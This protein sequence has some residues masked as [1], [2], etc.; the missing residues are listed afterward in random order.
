MVVMKKLGKANAGKIAD[1]NFY[2]GGDGV[3]GNGSAVGS[4]QFVVYNGT[5]E[6]VTVTGLEPNRV[7]GVAVIEYNHSESCGTID[8]Q[9]K[10]FASAYLTTGTLNAALNKFRVYPNPVR[11]EMN[12]ILTTPYQGERNFKLIDQKGKLIRSFTARVEPGENR[13]AI[14]I[15]RYDLM[16]GTYFLKI[17]DQSFKHDTFRVLIK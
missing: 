3:F 17:E 11:D 2:N 13:L 7:Y 9:T 14:D 15:S 6:S 4:E 12:I 5:G 1:G 8:Y 10:K 16:R